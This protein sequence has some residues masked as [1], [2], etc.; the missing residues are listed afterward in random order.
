MYKKMCIFFFL[1]TGKKSVAFTK[2]I[3]VA[4]FVFRFK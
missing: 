1:R 4:L 2:A 3:L